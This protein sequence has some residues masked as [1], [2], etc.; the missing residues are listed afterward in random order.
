[1]KYF[2]AIQAQDYAAAKWAVGQRLRNSSDD[3]IEKAFNE[4]KIL[5]THA[6]RPTW[7][8]ILPEDIRWILKL[9]S[10]RVK[11]G[12][13]SSEKKLGLDETIF[14][15]SNSIITKVLKGNKQINTARNCCI[16]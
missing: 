2:G 12:M 16:S 5:R 1:M 11:S 10:P 13:A 6:M 3:L 4:G 7:H 15:K 8:F 9:T 14:K